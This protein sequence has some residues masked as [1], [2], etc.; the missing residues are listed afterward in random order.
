MVLIEVIDVDAVGLELGGQTV[1]KE[2]SLQAKQGELHCLLGPNG[3]G[4]TMTNKLLANIYKSTKGSIAW[5]GKRINPFTTEQERIENIRKLGYM[6]QK[7]VFLHTSLRSNIA[8]P[9]EIQGYDHQEIDDIVNRKIA[10]FNL[11]KLQDKHPSK[12]SIGQQQKAALLRALVNDPTLLIL[13]EPTA[14]LDMAN[15]KWFEQFIRD[16]VEN[17]RKIVFW[18]THDQFQAKRVADI[19]HVLINGTLLESGTPDQIFNGAKN[20]LVRKYLSGEL[21]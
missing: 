18:T 6:N 12:L 13:D 2:A 7:P 16:Q 21:L 3:A 14:S 19:V 1:L 10:H 4:K 17:E 20:P 8:L 9:L 5:D 11:Q 15:V